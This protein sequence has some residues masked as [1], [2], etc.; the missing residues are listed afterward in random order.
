MKKE[1]YFCSDI[2]RSAWTTWGRRG[3]RWPAA[4][5]RRRRTASIS[6]SRPTPCTSGRRTV[7]TGSAKTFFRRRNVARVVSPSLRQRQRK[8]LQQTMNDSKRLIHNEFIFLLKLS[9][10]S[11]IRF[12]RLGFKVE[13]L[14]EKLF[15]STE[16]NVTE[17][18]WPYLIVPS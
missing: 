13:E 7:D 17:L 3:S 14:P 2:F 5:W 8:L 1:R 16:Q 12:Q 9:L 11:W 4:A 15:G 18:P 10:V 6:S